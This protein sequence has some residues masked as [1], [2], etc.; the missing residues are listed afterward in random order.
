MTQRVYLKVDLPPKMMLTKGE[1]Y[2]VELGPQIYNPQTLEPAPLIYIVLC[3]D[4]KWRKCGADNFLKLQEAREMIID[5]I[6][7]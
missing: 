1:F 7:K 5:K 2:D 4:G 6:L 3:D